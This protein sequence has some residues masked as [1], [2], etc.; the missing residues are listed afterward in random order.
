M[1]SSMGG[2]AGEGRS[3]RLISLSAWAGLIAKHKVSGIATQQTVSQM[4][5]TKPRGLPDIE[6]ITACFSLVSNA[7]RARMRS[8]FATTTCTKNKNSE[9]VA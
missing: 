2:V 5:R 3:S 7:C 9:R 4:L 6:K 1:S 8:G